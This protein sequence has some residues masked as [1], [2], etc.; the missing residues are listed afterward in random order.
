MDANELLYKRERYT[1]LES[2]KLTVT[3]KE[4]W[5]GQGVISWFRSIYVC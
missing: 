3:K 1:D 4:M 5:R 2:K